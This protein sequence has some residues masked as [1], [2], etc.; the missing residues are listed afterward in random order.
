MVEQLLAGLM[1]G[2]YPNVSLI[3]YKLILETIIV[4]SLFFIERVRNRKSVNMLCGHLTS[5]VLK[6]KSTK[7]LG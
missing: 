7:F 2:G 4:L 6:K 5:P 1:R 3:V